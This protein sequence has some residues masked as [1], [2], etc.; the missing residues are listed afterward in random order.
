MGI[1]VLSPIHART[2]F[3]IVGWMHVIHGG[4]HFQVIT[5]KPMG[6]F[7]ILGSSDPG[8][9]SAAPIRQTNEF[10]FFT[11][12]IDKACMAIKKNEKM[13]TTTCSYDCGAR[14]LLK[15][16]VCDGKITRIGTD[17]RRGAALKACVR[18]LSQKE[19]VYSPDRLTRPLQRIG[20]RGRGRFEPVSWDQALDTITAE[21]QRVKETY[22]PQSIFLMDYYGNEGALHGSRN[23]AHRFFNLFGGCTRVWGSTS[24]EGADF[25]SRATLGTGFTGNS[26]DNL[27]HADLIILW[28]WDPLVSRFRPDTAFYLSMAKRK[29]TKI[30]SVDPRHSLSSVSLAE[31]WIP[32]KPGTDTAMLIAMAY[33]LFAEN[34]YQAEFVEKYT[35]GI[36]KFKN[37][38]LG[39]EDGVAKTPGWAA[40]IT[41]VS[42]DD[43]Q[44]L[45][46]EYA[47]RKPAALCTGWAPG[48]TAYGEQFHRAAITLAAMTANI[49]VGGGHVAGGTDRM[50]FGRLARSF[51][52][53]PDRFPAVNV[54]E[55]FEA[56]LNGKSGGYPVDYKL[57]YVVGC[58]LLNQFLN[59]NKGVSALKKPDFI[60][61]HELFMTPTARYADMVLPVPHFTEEEDIGLPWLGGPYYI[62]MNRVIEPKTDVRSDLAIFT[63]LADRLGLVGY[64]PKSDRAWLEEFVA[65][66]PTLPDF[67]SF[68]DRGEHRL[69]LSEPWV[70]FK[71]QINDPLKHPF[72]TPSGKIE[73]YSRQIEAMNNDR[74]PAIPRYIEPWE[75][76]RDA[77]DGRY[78]IQLVSPHARTR[79][80]SQFDNILRLKE[81]GDDAIWL[82]PEDAR[83][84]GIADGDRVIVFNDRGRLRSTAKVTDRI[85]AGV[86]GL[87][88]GAWYRPDSQGIDDG[89]CVNVLTRDAMSPCGA[90]ACNS[91]LVEIQPEKK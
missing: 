82:N 39:K 20:K 31:K 50:E 24:Q 48:R 4:V 73:I 5:L 78:P 29:G 62:Y 19:V 79:V 71:N 87:D 89:G 25:A 36:E 45:A 6:P 77:V 21:L 46:R 75:G 63:A 88:A 1:R 74:I 51:P 18:G 61:V 52:A 16:H 7:L 38:V 3:F 80:N 54:A 59:I 22:G 66:T 86:A 56:L 72:A 14:C 68:K 69:E 81:S 23:A 57:L 17:N 32:I 27:L 43:I 70:A 10:D 30:V 35:F 90:F 47:G 49:G 85:M 40:D 60:V 65:A 41:G 12:I 53:V 26:R 13:I 58:N 8:A 33:V 15:V 2:S 64:N 55:V 83:K 76:P 28:G 34:L 42:A 91:C 44:S 67:K 37:Y 9:G 84:R 11:I